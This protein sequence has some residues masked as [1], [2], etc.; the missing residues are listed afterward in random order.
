[1]ASP[2]EAADHGCEAPGW[3]LCMQMAS[4]VARRNI[5]PRRPGYVGCCA[6]SLPDR[7]VVDGTVCD[8]EDTRARSRARARYGGADERRRVA[9]GFRGATAETE[10]S[11]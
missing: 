6:R 5:R 2:S 1:M 4:R 9:D 8:E 10:P 7:R 11:V 3:V